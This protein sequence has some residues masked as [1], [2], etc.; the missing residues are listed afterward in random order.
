MHGTAIKVVMK[1]CGTY[2]WLMAASIGVAFIY[3]ATAQA[4]PPSWF[5][6]DAP[7]FTV[8][9]DQTPPPYTRDCVDQQI[10]VEKNVWYNYLDMSDNSGACVYSKD[11][12]RYALSNRRYGDWWR[13]LSDKSFVIGL[14]HDSSMYR[15]NN[16]SATDEP[17]FTPH[18]RSLVYKVRNGYGWGQ[19][20][21]IYDDIISRLTKADAHSYAID[22]VDTPDFT[23][24]RPNGNFLPVNAI[25]SSSNGKWLAFE[26]IDLGIMRFNMDT[27]E[28]KRISNVAPRYGHGM[29][30]TMNLS[31]S[32]SGE[33]IAL[34]GYATPFMIF[35]ATP[36]CGDTVVTDGMT[37]RTPIA[38]P[39]PELSLYEHIL[40]EV[41]GFS[42]AMNIRLNKDGSEMQF[43][44]LA[45]YAGATRYRTEYTMRV[46]GDLPR[47]PIK[48]LALGDSFSSGEG[49]ADWTLLFLRDNHYLPGTDIVGDAAKGVPQER[50]HVSDRSYPFL[51]RTMMDIPV[52]KMKSVACSGAKAENDYFGNGEGYLG[53]DDRLIN[54]DA[55]DLEIYRNDALDGFVAGRIQQ[56]EFVENYKPDVVTLTAGGNDANFGEIITA[57]AGSGVCDYAA[58]LEGRKKVSDAINKQ[59]TVLVDLYATAQRK[60][61]TT[62]VYAIGYPQFFSAEHE[63]CNLNVRLEQSERVMVR[64]AVVYMNDVI[65]AAAMAAGVRYIDIEGALGEHVLCGNQEAY[66]TGL[67]RSGKLS[68]NLVENFGQ[69]S[70][71][72]NANGHR[73]IADAIHAALGVNQTLMT[74]NY[75][76]VEMGSSCAK[77]D[78]VAPPPTP[79]FSLSNAEIATKYLPVPILNKPYVQKVRIRC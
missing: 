52:V 12:W 60:S 2:S 11:G 70:F 78:T 33:Y 58:S 76:V 68:F 36:S 4:T 73:S 24:A 18:A 57:C 1:F 13:H 38:V 7:I 54:L 51:L 65:E 31:I 66:V 6:Q 49:D 19:K 22:N 26:V 56:F 71:H 63:E 14:G 25:A 48:Y 16:L 69:E 28:V 61:A 79:Y 32:D 75:C 59:F 62:K 35:H 21:I 42:D 50:C 55:V 40:K 23:L 30:P 43:S 74:Y 45:Y 44:A 20:L 34:G 10:M 77:S 29:N 9:S 39:C 3:S 64:E 15:V 46:P 5:S 8:D 72:P 67:A 41:P 53:Q 17:V 47:P 27:H 37:H